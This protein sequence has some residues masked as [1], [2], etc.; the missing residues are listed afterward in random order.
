VLTDGRTATARTAA[1]AAAN[2][3][4]VDLALD[5]A[6]AKRVA[7]AASDACDREAVATATGAL[8]EAGFAVSRFDD[9]AGLAVMRT[10]AMLANEAADAAMLGIATPADIDLAMLKGVN[11]P[12]GPLAWGDAIGAVRIAGVIGNLAAHYGDGRYRVSPR[13][14]R[15]A[16]SGKPVAG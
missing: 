5:Y 9:V 13:L 4:L 11:Y 16:Q 10:V 8:Q 14:A 2:I 15:A 3:V 1:T 7:I 12:R 6:T